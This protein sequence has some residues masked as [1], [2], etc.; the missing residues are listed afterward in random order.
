MMDDVTQAKEDGAAAA[1]EL[2]LDAYRDLLTPEELDESR[3][4][5]LDVLE[6]HPVGRLLAERVR[7][8]R[9]VRTSHEIPTMGIPPAPKSDK[10]KVRGGGR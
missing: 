7:E 4:L 2:A 6:A 1:V 3:L 8:R 9:P 10:G 5:L